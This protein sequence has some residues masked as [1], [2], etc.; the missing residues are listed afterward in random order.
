VMCCSLWFLS[1]CLVLRV[2]STVLQFLPMKQGW[3]WCCSFVIP[4]FVFGYFQQSTQFLPMKAGIEWC[5][6]LLIPFF[7]FG[8]KSIFQQSYNFYLWKQGLSDVLLLLF[9]I[10]FFV[11]GLKSIFNSPTISTWSRSWVLLLCD[12][13]F[14]FGLK[15]IFNS[16]TQYLWKQ[17]LSDV[18]LFCDSFLC[19]WSGI[20]VHPLPTWKQGLVMCF[21]DSFLC[22]WS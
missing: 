14:V 3:E 11:F 4:F 6:A 13:F 1:L 18:L 17:G 5:A 16:P 15:S 20:R 2:F 19:V 21:L 10:P 7:V 8:L 9:V 22:V 12:S